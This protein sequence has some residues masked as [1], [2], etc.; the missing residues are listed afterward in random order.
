[1]ILFQV[2]TRNIA[3]YA[4]QLFSSGESTI[5]T[6]SWGRTIPLTALENRI[7]SLVNT[8]STAEIEFGLLVATG[9]VRSRSNWGAVTSD[10]PTSR[11]LS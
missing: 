4:F 8:E 10:L 6:L 5:L 1:M 2:F 9:P 3:H 7:S 11:N